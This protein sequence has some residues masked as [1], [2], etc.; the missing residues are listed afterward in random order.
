[1]L[2]TKAPKTLSR[3]SKI[4]WGRILGTCKIL[5][6]ELQLL[7]VALEAKDEADECRLKIKEEGW[8]YIGP[9]GRPCLHPL[10]KQMKESRGIFMRAW[11]ILG[12]RSEDDIRR[13]GRPPDNPVLTDEE[14]D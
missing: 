9:D 11:K 13:P 3:G 7:K 12:F 14:E 6:A 10:A 2:T 5:P 8:T 4:L 1:M